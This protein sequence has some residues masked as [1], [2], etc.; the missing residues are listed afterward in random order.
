MPAMQSL[1]EVRENF[2][3][4]VSEVTAQVEL[5]RRFFNEPSRELMEKISSRDDY[6]D[7]LK[8]VI[9]EQSFGRLMDPRGIE[10]GKVVEIRALNTITANLERIADFAVNILGQIGHLST[11]ESSHP[12]DFAPFFE[13]V[14]VGLNAVVRAFDDRNANKA[15][16]ICQ[17]EFNLDQLHAQT[18]SR[19]L[20]ELEQSEHRS[21][22]VTVL[23]ISHYLE[24]MGD[25]LLNIGEALIFV[26][27]GEKMKIRQYQALSDT[28][29]ASGLEASVGQVE[30]E[31]IW[32]TRGGCRIG[33]VQNPRPESSRPVLFKQGSKRKLGKEK[34]NLEVWEQL[35]P[36]L[37]PKVW[38]FQDASEGDG[39]ILLEYLPGCTMQDLIINGDETNLELSAHLLEAILGKVWWA[40]KE[41]NCQRPDFVGQI[42]SRQEAVYRL[43]PELETKP[44]AIG[45]LRLP[46]FDDL[47]EA[48]ESLE[49]ELTA[50]YAVRIHG[51]LNLNN[52]IFDPMAQGL[53]FI[54]LH[55]SAMADCAQDISVFLISNFRLP[56][57][58]PV[59]RRRINRVM[60]RFLSFALGFAKGVGDTAFQARLALG[61]GRSLFSST[62]FEMNPGFAREMHLR[63]VYLLQRVVAHQGKDWS[64]FQLPRQTLVYP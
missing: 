56:V 46:S 55:R 12:L 17:C 42:R 24:R 23:F 18:F 28:L 52:V 39:S 1:E 9:E 25:C 11:L 7:N 51:D 19:V 27:V 33:T 3:F 5:T 34:E 64:R 10:R 53:H 59:V 29:A 50:P 37:P 16:R 36:G 20:S 8:S 44:L 32:G 2:R 22:L 47:L 31:S 38:A 57:F 60:G 26:L 15:F 54:D 4:I 13:E 48:L 41:P 40:T 61:L 6:I 62:R 14:L 58:E 45:N 21:D 43:H 35:A 30:F 63:A 49:P